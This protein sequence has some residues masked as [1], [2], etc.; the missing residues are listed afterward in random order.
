VADINLY[1]WTLPDGTVYHFMDSGLC[2]TSL[3]SGDD[4]DDLGFGVYYSQTG[5]ISASLVNCPVSAGFRL[6]CKQT[7]SSSERKTQILYTNE[8]AP[9][10]YIR[11]QTS[12]GWNPWRMV[13]GTVTDT[14]TMASG[15]GTLST[16][17]IRRSGNI[18]YLNMYATGVDIPTTATVIATIPSEYYP[19]ATAYGVAIIGV[20]PDV[21]YADVTTG[22]NIRIRGG[23]AQSSVGI[24]ISMMWIIA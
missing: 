8:T 16:G 18:V 9:R 14:P 24:R 17:A 2:G 6:E 20:G 10:I 19:T 4:L 21:A 5:T 11:T 12:G 7:I 13:A 1:T 15:M 3:E 23:A 22:G